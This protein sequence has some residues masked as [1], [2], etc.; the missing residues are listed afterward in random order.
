MIRRFL[1]FAIDKPLLNHILL[2]FIVL[3]SI[4]AYLNIPKEIF[5]P[6]NMDKVTISG[7]YSG[8]SADV[9]DKM[10]VKTIED[11]LQNIDELYN[12]KTTIQNG[13]FSII[14]DIKT[15]SDNITVLSDVKNILSSVKKD[16]PADM[17]EPIAKIQLHSF[18]LVLIALAGDSSKK[19]LLNLAEDLKSDLSQ[20]KDLSDITIRG[21]ADDELVI[22]I[23]EQKLLA[24]ELNPSLAVASLKNISSIFPIGTIKDRGKHLYISTFNGEKTK[25]SIEN[26]I[27]SVG[28]ARV[29]IG[30]IADIEFRLSDESE[31]SHY[32]G[33]RNVSINV[34]KSKDGNAIALVRQIRE[35]LKEKTDKS[36]EVKYEIYTDTSIWI[37]NRLNTVFANIAFGLMLVFLAMLIFINRGIAVVVAIGIPVSF[38]IGLIATEIMG[39]SLNMLSL[40]G[41]L[42]ALGMLV[43]EAIVVAENIYRHLEEG[44]E[45]REAAIVGAT[46]MF[47][48]VLTAT[49]TTVFAFLPMLLLTGE[50]GMFIKIIPIMITVLLLSSLFE[51]FYFLP[52]H[53]HDFLKVS[54]DE[55]FTKKLWKRLSSWHN[56][57]LHFVF[58]AKWISLIIIVVSILSL[59]FVFIKNSKFQL[60][61]DFDTTQIYVY[62][63]VNVNNELEDTERI[64]TAL[65]K[66]LLAHTNEDDF[67]SIT[68]VIGFKMDAKNMLETGDNLFHIFIDLKERAPA[69]A[70]DRYINPYLS[71]DYNAEVLTRK[72]DA[73]DIAKEIDKLIEPFKTQKEN[74]DLL[75]EELVVKVPGAGV[76]A[77]D[78][79]ISLSG[80][81][82][83]DI[84]AGVKYLRSSLDKI[85]GVN[86]S[87]D[88]ANPG[89]KE[90][91]LRINEYGQQL[92]F[93]EELISAELRSYY[94]KGEYGKMFN[95]EGLVRIK[96]ESGINKEISSIYNIEVQVPKTD[97]YVALSDVCEFIMLQ[98]F[99]S[100]KKEDGTRL[101]TVLAT[102]NKK[103]ITSAEV[104]KKLEPVFEK[105][106][107]DGYKIDIKGEE[108][109]NAKNKREMMQSAIIAIFL[110]F[111]TLVWLFDSIKKSLI[112]ISTIPLVLLGVYFGHWVMDINL[113]MTGMIG[114]VG[115]AGVVVNDGLIVVN[116]IKHADDTEEL[117]K[118]AGTRLRPIILTS[119]TTVLGLSTLIFFASGQAMILQPMAISLGFGIAWATVLN[120]IYVPLLYAVVFKI[121][122]RVR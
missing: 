49:L 46:E 29:R 120:L 65:E 62:G 59:T 82:E 63:K 118:R 110:I 22:T 13:S 14:S 25:K 43:D 116:F 109:E 10:V 26:T 56:K 94:L 60:F 100:I 86:N 12:I 18:P 4:F 74:G 36:T 7:G 102:L 21:D 53:A 17:S 66:K 39:D 67:S 41:A 32:N 61:P 107:N 95:D 104:M 103:V 83:K 15:G 57:A 37:K 78:I 5:P 99:V 71:I 11:D 113:T 35:I 50:M 20:L 31:L 88:D 112:V 98:G 64:I 87:S 97:N 47:P 19:E 52:L 80:K 105:L 54:H 73:K 30:D 27:I 3:L 90:L 75:Y 121:K 23:N 81:S 70:F 33:V 16:L 108:K 115:L 76:V 58:R 79:E 2:T 69:N 24:F 51:A 1:E 92:G 40:L 38:M 6:M 117:M 114:I 28:D 84:L 111:I 48:A 68:S 96:I 42:I 101:R 106:K 77:S 72:N 89:E 85:E 45:K 91:K 122:D 9:L 119:L 55:S 34:T 8:T 93:N 44:M